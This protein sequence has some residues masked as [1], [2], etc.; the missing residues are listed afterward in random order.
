MFEISSLKKNGF[1]ISACSLSGSN[2]AIWSLFHCSGLPS[3][4]SIY[5]FLSLVLSCLLFEHSFVSCWN[6][7]AYSNRSSH[8]LRY[9]D[10]QSCIVVL[11]VY[12]SSFELEAPFWVLCVIDLNR[13]R[14]N[15]N[16]STS[17]GVLHMPFAGWNHVYL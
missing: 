14:L 15:I 13:V 17:E 12:I 7:V 6:F 2:W 1:C 8:H 4:S 10:C 16:N 11:I 5:L 9:I 3:C